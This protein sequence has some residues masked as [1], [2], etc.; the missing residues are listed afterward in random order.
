MNEEHIMRLMQATAAVAMAAGMTV[1]TG[2]QATMP[3]DTMAMKAAPTSYTGCVEAGSTAGTFVLT[4]VSGDVAMTKDTMKK[5]AM[6]KDAMAK[7]DMAKDSMKKDAM[8]DGMM[9][10][11]MAKDGMMSAPLMLVGSAVNLAPHVGHKV[12]LTGKSAEKMA[13]SVATLK[14]VSE[15]CQ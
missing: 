6:A 14:L 1:G 13:F 11:G 9:K 15:S 8:K 10:D 3:K 7:D 4:H 5:G 12:T 2:A